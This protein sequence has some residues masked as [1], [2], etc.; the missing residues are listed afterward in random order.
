MS[1]LIFSVLLQ[2]AEGVHRMRILRVKDDC[3][4]QTLET[5]KNDAIDIATSGEAVWRCIATF[6]EGVIRSA[7]HWNQILI[8]LF[9]IHHNLEMLEKAF[10]VNANRLLDQSIA[11]SGLVQYIL[12]QL[13]RSRLVQFLTA[14]NS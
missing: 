14:L 7:P 8:V 4:V 11:A 10:S 6:V 9:S 3:T 2:S 12:N 1:R 13:E 5:V